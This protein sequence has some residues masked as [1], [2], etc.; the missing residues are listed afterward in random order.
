LFKEA[1]IFGVG[2]GQVFVI[3]NLD[4]KWS[5]FIGI[6]NM[7][8]SQKNSSKEFFCGHGLGLGK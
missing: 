4:I 2:Q 8:F 5:S 1:F 6:F 3:F 7:F